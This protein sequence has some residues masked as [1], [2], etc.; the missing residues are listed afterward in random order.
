MTLSLTWTSTCPQSPL[1]RANQQSLACW[2]EVNC[3]SHRSE[4][5][6]LLSALAGVRGLASEPAVGLL[7][8]RLYLGVCVHM[9]SGGSR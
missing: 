2:V 7:P 1:Q 9:L 3:R 8:R 6:Q 4:Q 5:A